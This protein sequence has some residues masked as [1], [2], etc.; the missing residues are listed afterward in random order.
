M[1]A[2]TLVTTLG[3]ALI[4]RIVFTQPMGD[5]PG[6]AATIIGLRPDPEAPEIVMQVSHETF[7]EI[8]VFECEQVTLLG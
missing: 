4:G 2:E 7:G 1:T 6:G 8:G 5:Y 3:S